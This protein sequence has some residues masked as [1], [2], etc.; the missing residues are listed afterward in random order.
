MSKCIS[1]HGE[2]SEHEYTGQ[3]PTCDYCGQ[4]SEMIAVD[5]LQT[6]RTALVAIQELHHPAITLKGWDADGKEITEWVC[7][8][9]TSIAEKGTYFAFPCATRRLAD[10]ALTARTTKNGD[11][12]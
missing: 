3:N 11:N 7:K 4:V 12:K 9:C 8:Y 1:V 2:F 6:M 10:D 5:Q